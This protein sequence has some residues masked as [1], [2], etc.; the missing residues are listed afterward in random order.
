MCFCD[1]RFCNVEECSVFVDYW[2]ILCNG[3]PETLPLF[4]CVTVIC[5]CNSPLPLHSDIEVARAQTPKDVGEVAE[6][7]G[8]LETEVDLYGK[9]KAK[10]SLSVLQRLAHQKDG[11]YVVVAGWDVVS[12]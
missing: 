12:I 8:L 4:L 3:I 1:I 6:E 9:K 10:V 5:V 2:S 7:I 11:K